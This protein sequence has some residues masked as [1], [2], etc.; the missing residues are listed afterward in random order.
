MKVKVHI[1]NNIEALIKLLDQT[2]NPKSMDEITKN[3]EKS[4]SK[5]AAKIEKEQA[6]QADAIA[7]EN[8][9]VDQNA[10][11]TLAQTEKNNH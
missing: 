10:D 5:I 4:Y 11:L 8:K 9:K 6:K 7:K 1:E 3:I 2:G